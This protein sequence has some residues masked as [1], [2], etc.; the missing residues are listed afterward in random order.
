MSDDAPD[1]LHVNVNDLGPEDGAA[2]L[3]EH[4]ATLFASDVFFTANEKHIAVSLRHLGLLRL[5]SII[6][7]ELGR[8]CV[9]HIKAVAGMDVAEKRRPL[10]GRCV[11]QREN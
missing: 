5:A 6:P 9:A 2:R 8:R 7:N 4:A 10:D 3:L 1:N 11:Y